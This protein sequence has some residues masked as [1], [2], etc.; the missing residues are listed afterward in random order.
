MEGAAG[1]GLGLLH[2]FC[3][4]EMRDFC[5]QAGGRESF[6]DVVT[7]EVDVGINL[8]SDAVVALVALESD[9]VSSGTNP[10]RF[11]VDLEG[12][13]PNAEMV[14]RSNDADGLSVSPR[15]VL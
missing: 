3:G 2:G 10:K 11:A 15:I 7:L 1:G 14:A 13:F 12:R 6:F 9:V 4:E 5:D 8:V